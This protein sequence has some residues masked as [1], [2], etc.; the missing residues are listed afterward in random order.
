[1]KIKN[2]IFFFVTGLIFS[3]ITTI[4]F[5]SAF[6]KE[7]PGRLLDQSNVQNPKAH[8]AASMPKGIILLLLA[9][10]VIG[11]LGVSRKKKDT[12][13]AADRHASDQTVQQPEV[14]EEDQKRITGNL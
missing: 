1:M 13:S 4:I 9:V 8:A 3:G 2:L 5:F 6:N 14:A 10:G 7:E 12:T 11:A